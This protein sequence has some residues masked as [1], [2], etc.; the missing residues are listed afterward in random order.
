MKKVI[1]ILILFVLTGKCLPRDSSE[2]K[3][4][5]EEISIN[6]GK[7]FI[8]GD[9][10]MPEEGDNFPVVVYCTG[11]GPTD[12][13]QSIK[14]SRAIRQFIKS[15]FAFFIDDKPGSGD[16]KGE[17][18]GDSLFRERAMILAKEIEVLKNHKMINSK[19]IGLYGSSQAGYVMSIALEMSKDIAFMVAWSCPGM[20]SI[21][22]SAYLVKKQALCGGSVAEDAEMLHKYYIQRATA[23]TYKEYLE[24]A[25]FLDKHP[26]ITEL[27]WGGVAPEKDF[28]PVSENSESFLNP[29]DY[30]G[31]TEIPVLAIFGEKDT[32]IDPVQGAESYEKAFK[33]NGNKFYKIVT[34]PDVDHNM[35]LTKTGSLK[36]QKE[37]YKAGTVKLSK[38]FLETIESWLDELKGYFS[39]TNSKKVN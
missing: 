28:E 32:Q 26:V 12:R 2:V 14:Y 1:L 18:S 36:E 7:F 10:L 16:S 24:A 39:G 8:K 17:F 37:N 9:L 27:G 22:Q 33:T 23:N 11:S 15:G 6:A 25:E 5:T 34:I 30:I 35:C 31:K 19:Q 20:N 21:E 3:F 29:A 38:K 13:K 4:R